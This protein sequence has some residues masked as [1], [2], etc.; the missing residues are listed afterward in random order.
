MKFIKHNLKNIS[1]FSYTVSVRTTQL[2]S[3]KDI[4][5]PRTLSIYIIT[6]FEKKNQSNYQAFSKSYYF[7]TSGAKYSGVPQKVFVLAP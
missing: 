5:H 6:D 1:I 2:S 4:L 3:L 7:L